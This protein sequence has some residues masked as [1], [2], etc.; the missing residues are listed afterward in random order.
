[1]ATKVS[2]GDCHTPS[3]RPLKSAGRVGRP[4][5]LPPAPAAERQYRWP[6]GERIPFCL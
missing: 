2:D 5:G 3:N 1:M 6:V 4:D